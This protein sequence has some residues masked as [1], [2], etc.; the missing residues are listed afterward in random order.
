MSKPK[1][2]FKPPPV[3]YVR[4]V[5]VPRAVFSQYCDR[6]WPEVITAAQAGRDG[7]DIIDANY[8]GLPVPA[9][10]TAW[11]RENPAGG[12]FLYSQNWVVDDPIIYSHFL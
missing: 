6:S 3:R 8:F 1:P 7:L 10:Q 9:S 12:C 2:E 4:F 5:Q 11:L